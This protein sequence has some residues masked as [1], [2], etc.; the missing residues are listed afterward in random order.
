MK[1]CINTSSFPKYDGD[2]AGAFVLELALALKQKGHEI[3]VLCPV[4]GSADYEREIKGI[5]IFRYRYAF[6]ASWQC[7]VGA[8]KPAV[9]LIKENPLLL[10]FV[11]FLL[12]SQFISLF[13]LVLKEKPDAV[14]SHWLIPQGLITALVCFLLGKKHLMTLHSTDVYLASKLPFS[15]LL[16][17]M[18][19]NSAKACFVTSGFVKARY[20]RV[21]GRSSNAFIMPM[22]VDPAKFFPFGREKRD[23]NKILFI[24]RLHEIKGINYLIEAFVLLANELPD[25]KLEI[26]GDGE[27]RAALESLV[28]KYAL[29]N[30]IQFSGFIPNN[31]LAAYY[32]SAACIAVPSLLMPSGETEGMPVVIVEAMTCGIPVIASDVG[33]ISDLVKDSFNGFLF[34]PGDASEIA[35]ALRKFFGSDINRLSENALQTGEKYHWPRLAEHYEKAI[36]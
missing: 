22:G 5:K 30:R 1:I 8:G 17:R 3:I 28:R 25:L 6:P 26:A 4:P 33:G 11:P 27:E 23:F 7:L 19:E 34:K 24:G 18:A 2:Y 9:P 16:C 35:L 31:K 13:F 36:L 14:N 10:F 29:E 20:E 21:L 32:N 15:S 12:L